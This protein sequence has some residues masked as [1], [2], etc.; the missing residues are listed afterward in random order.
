ML[1]AHAQCVRRRRVAG[2]DGA[3]GQEQHLQRVQRTLPALDAL[4]VAHLPRDQQVQHASRGQPGPGREDD[5]GNRGQQRQ[6]QQPGPAQPGRR[7]GRLPFEQ[8]GR[9]FGIGIAQG[10][11]RRFQLRAARRVGHQRAQALRLVGTFRIVRAAA[12]AP[13]QGLAAEDADAG[14]QALVVARQQQ[15]VP[16]LVVE[17]GIARGRHPVQLGDVAVG[18]EIVDRGRVRPGKQLARALPER[19]EQ[20]G[21]EGG[22][23]RFQGKVGK[24]PCPNYGQVDKNQYECALG[25]THQMFVPQHTAAR[26]SGTMSRPTLTRRYRHERTAR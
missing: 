8:Q 22:H 6:R 24:Y 2:A 20:R 7:R 3:A 17:R 1:G 10:A 18:K 11:Q 25:R 16:G 19:V 9:R 14:A 4:V 15:V 12:Q 23:G 13:V 5:A 26:L 21:G